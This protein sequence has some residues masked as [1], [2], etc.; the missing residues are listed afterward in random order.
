MRR[1][2]LFS[3][4]NLARFFMIFNINARKYLSP[5][6]LKPFLLSLALTSLTELVASVPE[7][8]TILELNNGNAVLAGTFKR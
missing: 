7:P 6:R 3:G 8:T 4:L 1:T 2:C 5:S